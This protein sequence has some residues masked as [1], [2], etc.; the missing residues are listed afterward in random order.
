[1][2]KPETRIMIEVSTD[3]GIS[4]EDWHTTKVVQE[5]SDQT[6]TEIMRA[7]K[8]MIPGLLIAHGFSINNVLGDEI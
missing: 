8:A 3:A 7:I 6:C 2:T 1:M 4:G 5:L